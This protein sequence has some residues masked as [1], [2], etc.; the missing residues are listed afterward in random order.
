[1]RTQV[2][3][4]HTMAVLVVL[5][6]V[7]GCGPSEE[8][9][10]VPGDAAVRGYIQDVLG[11]PLGQASVVLEGSRSFST[12]SDVKG[13]YEILDVAAPAKYD[14]VVSR[15][16]GATDYRI[17]IRFI[18]LATGALIDMPDLQVQAT[19]KIQGT[20]TLRGSGTYNPT[21]PNDANIK[22]EVVG[23]N[24]RTVTDANGAYTLSPVEVAI[25]APRIGEGLGIPAAA[26][27]EILYSRDGYGAKRVENIAVAPGAV[28]SVPSV[29]LL[30]LDPQSWGAL[31]GRVT[32]EAAP[33]GDN[34]GVA[35]TIDG[36]TRTMTTTSGGYW[37]FDNLP[38]G[39]YAIRFARSYYYTTIVRNQTIVA[40]IPVTAV[41]DVKLSNHRR[42]NENLR[43][44]DLAVSPSGNQIAYI[45][46]EAVTGGEI[47]LVSPDGVAFNQVITSGAKAVGHRGLTWTHDEQELLFVRYLGD[48]INAYT[49]GVT[50]NTG[51]SVRSLLSSGTDYF[52]V[53]W[54]PDH[55]KF[56]FY[57]SNTLYSVEVDRSTGVTE[58][59]TSTIHTI[60]PLGDVTA[61]T[62]MEWANTGRL[63]YGAVLSGAPGEIWTVFAGGGSSIPLNP[64]EPGG[65]SSVLS[66]LVSP[67]FS[68]DWGRVAF[69]VQSPSTSPL[70]I[71]IC[72]VDGVDAVRVSESPGRSLTWRP[73]GEKIFYLD[74]EDRICELLVPPR[75]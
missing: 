72:D 38:T 40:G 14:M 4:R 56:A 22:V 36:T 64:T 69:S 70:G 62:G 58:A 11:A 3:L 48:P 21:Y 71:W 7:L 13:S 55:R 6:V 68:P 52:G 60:A 10:W 30:P 15:A 17:R 12:Y 63:V 73:D 20:A 67:T 41:A 46:S 39:T 49:V 24:I 29:E 54:A 59:V 28:T 32:L 53:A 34:S 57:R 66:P 37:R 31:A 65:A 43:A 23:T 16:L 26:T 47:G 25:A 74:A 51:S 18:E 75:Q 61:W 42:I 2:S 27:Y 33:S 35:V 1:M 19:A 9:T 5:V 8:L 44:Y 50:D 45:T